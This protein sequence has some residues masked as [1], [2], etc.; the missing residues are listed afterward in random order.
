MEN[1]N[2]EF[3]KYLGEFQPRRPR[4]LPKAVTSKKVWPW[5]IAAAAAI[6]IGLGISLWSL[7]GKRN[8]NDTHSVAHRT[9]TAST[10]EPAQQR[11]SSLA[12]TKLALKD[13]ERLDAEL[14]GA[15]R[16]MLPD[17]RGSG[18]TLRVLAKE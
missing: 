11:L 3:E 6:T 17:F 5:R 10:E 18:S 1:G 15:S 2:K 9:I 13:P 7:H 14:T 12:L 16:R 4:P 8:S